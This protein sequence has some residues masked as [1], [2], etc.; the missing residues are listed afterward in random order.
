MSNVDADDRR[1]SPP[2]WALAVALAAT[3][4]EAAKADPAMPAPQFVE[5][6]LKIGS[7]DEPKNDDFFTQENLK[8]VFHA[9]NVASAKINDGS[10]YFLADVPV[11]LDSW[12]PNAPARTV[13]IIQRSNSGATSIIINFQGKSPSSNLK[14]LTNALGPDWIEDRD[15]ENAEFLAV[16]REPF[17][18]PARPVRIITYDC[19][20]PRNTGC[21]M[22]LDFGPNDE[23][24]VVRLTTSF[25]KP[26]E[27]HLPPGGR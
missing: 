3:S 26:G 1:F 22:S 20:S 6:V 9:A 8:R 17:N 21:R 4:L 25:S 12:N 2:T 15:A 11:Q 19:T 27:P 7:S 13:F 23:L 14:S 18:P 16:A 24:Y 5:E 10:E